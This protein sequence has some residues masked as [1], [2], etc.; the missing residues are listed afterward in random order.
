MKPTSHEQ[1][2]KTKHQNFKTSIALIV[3]MLVLSCDK[4]VPP[5][6]ISDPET[7][8][9][10]ISYNH[11]IM[12]SQDGVRKY[13]F[14]TPLLEKYDEAK[15][16]FIEFRQGI[17]IQTF[18][19]T[20]SLSIESD[21]VADYAHFNEAKQ[22]WEGRGNVIARNLKED[23]ILYTEQLFWD[24]AQKKIYTDKPA[25]V[26]DRGNTHRGIGFEAD[27]KFEVWQFNRARGQIEVDNQPTDSTAVPADTT[28]V[29]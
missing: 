26:I 18:S 1:M 11:L 14:E 2:D 13:R 19:A 4:A 5:A 10:Q 8:P 21:L 9:T 23:K 16:P 27:E 7:T 29:Q 15:E 3:A 6:A 28:A 17:K 25:R 24:Q 20:D 22:L 12:E